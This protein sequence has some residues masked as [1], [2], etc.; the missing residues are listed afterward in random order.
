MEETRAHVC[1]SLALSGRATGLVPGVTRA[2]AQQRYDERPAH[3]VQS[4]AT[5]A[6]AAAAAS[7]GWW[8]CRP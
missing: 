3:D 5:D 2:L 8:S 1:F 7:L 4:I 6:V